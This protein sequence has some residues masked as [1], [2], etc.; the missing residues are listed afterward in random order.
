V[1]ALVTG[2]AGFVGGVVVQALLDGGDEVTVLDNLRSTTS[3]DVPKGATLVE[4][5][6]GDEEGVAEVLRAAR[7]DA[8]LHFAGRIESG[9]SMQEPEEFFVANVAETLT[10][11]R[12]LVAGGVERFVFSSSAAVYGDPQYT[13]IDEAHPTNA[14]SPYGESKL[15]VERTLA[16]LARLQRLRFASLRYFNAAGAIEGRPERHR[17]ESHL[18][19][20]ALEVAA[21]ERDALDLYGDD[22]ETPDGTCIRDYVHVAD[23]ATAH[24]LAVDALD[25]HASLVCNLG[26]GVGSSNAE[27][28]EA[29]RR[30]TGR[31]VPVRR[32]P[33]R[34]GDAVVLVAGNDLAR[35]V[36]GWVPVRSSL[37]EVVRDAWA[38]RA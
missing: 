35:A 1:R 11:L 2:G 13:P 14:V 27:V 23:L 36:L 5:S 32:A 16:W 19:P 15:L 29:V 30:E 18:I 24:V 25:E 10:L 8:C 4:C 37:A 33:R 6:V 34:G 26:A 38:A 7:F 22:Y 17:P 28:I 9:L 21:G 3:D 31:E 20:L 12:V